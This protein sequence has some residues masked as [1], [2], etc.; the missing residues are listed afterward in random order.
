MN[1]A[2][3]PAETNRARL[4]LKRTILVVESDS[5]SRELIA[6]MLRQSGFKT[7]TAKDG[8]DALNQSAHG[9]SRIDL[10]L[11]ETGVGGIQINELLRKLHR[12]HP[13]IKLLF[14]SGSLDEGFA[15]MLGDQAERLFLLKPFTRQALES[16]VIEVLR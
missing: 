15:L 7:V 5:E 2:A 14:M 12:R 11:T 13:G 1:P 6:E 10:L 9:S 3:P 8:L 16:K 4:G